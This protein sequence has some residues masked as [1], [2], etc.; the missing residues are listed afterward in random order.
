MIFD[1]YAVP[2]GTFREN[3][4]RDPGQKHLRSDY[5]GSKFNYTDEV[6]TPTKDTGSSAGEIKAPTEETEALTV[7]SK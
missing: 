4:L 6:E 3:L 5:Y 7:E 1:D 2:G